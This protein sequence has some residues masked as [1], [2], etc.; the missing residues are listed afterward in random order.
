MKTKEMVYRIVMIMA[1]CVLSAGMA[2]AFVSSD[3]IVGDNLSVGS[4]INTT[5]TGGDNLFAGG[6]AGFTNDFGA[7]NTFVGGSAGSSNTSGSINTFIGNLTGDSNTIG[8][9]NTYV[10]AGAG[11]F[12]T[13]DSNVFLGFLAGVFETGSN[14]LYIDNCLGFFDTGT[15]P[16]PLI[17][18]EFD[19]RIVALPDG[20]LGIGTTSP[21]SPLSV[22]DQVTTANRGYLGSQNTT[23]AASAALILRKSRGTEASPTA[24]ASGDYV[25]T[26]QF[27]SY[28][29]TSYLRN[30]FVGARANGTITATS[31]PTDIFFANSA[32][33]ESDPFA[34]GK[35]R[36]LINSVGNVGI[37]TTN[38]TNPLQ[39]GANANNAFIDSSGQY[40]SSSSREYKENIRNL[41]GEEASTVLSGLNP[42]KFNFKNDAD[43][44]ETAGF[45]AEDVPD[46]VAAKDRKSLT[47]TDIVAVLTKVLQE[48]SQVIES[49]QKTLVEQRSINEGIMEKLSKL[50]AEI[51]RLKSKDITARAIA[52]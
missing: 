2:R 46:L 52:Q 33:D 47:T 18:G 45:I 8:S 17:Y 32:T 22:T 3:L 10:G 37:G 23:D 6:F 31:V 19:N 39:F 38:P 20:K 44:K 30:A 51:N 15:C 12:S 40:H 5:D 25:G 14:K 11:A 29:G 27:R 9:L 50:E 1:V 35:V 43:K 28:S 49:Q 4:D 42:V 7:F 36:M 41:S 48:K 13:G 24:V 34:N 26:F 21:A 16:T